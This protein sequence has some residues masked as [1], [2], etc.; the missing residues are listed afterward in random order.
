MK[1][2]PRWRKACSLGSPVAGRG[3]GGA[4]ECPVRAVLSRHQYSLLWNSAER[5]GYEND[6]WLTFTQIRN[7]GGNI[8]KGERSTLAVFYLPQQREVVDSNGNTVL[9]ADGNPKV[10]S[11]AVVREFRLFNIQQCEGC[12]RRFHSLS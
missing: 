6:R 11:Y 9:D 12:R 4:D 7:A 1:L 2:S 3:T 8:H 10:M 5:Q